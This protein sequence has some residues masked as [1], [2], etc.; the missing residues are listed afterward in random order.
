MYHS[1]C[2]GNQYISLKCLTLRAGYHKEKQKIE[3]EEEGEEGTR[4]R[5]LDAIVGLR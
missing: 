2:F 3:I 4:W 1:A 5:S